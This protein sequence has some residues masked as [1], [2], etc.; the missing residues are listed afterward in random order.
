MIK[1][2][3]AFEVKLVKVKKMV[4]MMTLVVSV[5][6]DCETI[7]INFARLHS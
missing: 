4:P 5:R 6:L 2:S 3:N 1:D 7:V